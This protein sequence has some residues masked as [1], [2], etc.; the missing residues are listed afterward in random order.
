MV[1][2]GDAKPVGRFVRVE[3]PGKNKILSLAEVQV[4]Q[5][6]ENQAPR[7]AATQSG[8]GFDGPAGLAIDGNTNG[9]Y[10]EAKST[11]HTAASGDPWWELDLKQ[12]QPVDRIAIWNRTDGEIHTRLNGCR[13]TLLDEKRGT[14]L[15]TTHVKRPLG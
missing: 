12:A 8:T 6:G 1:P 14:R 2:P 15:D 4:F 5:G 7:G 3:I 9:H 10:T 11:T 13:I